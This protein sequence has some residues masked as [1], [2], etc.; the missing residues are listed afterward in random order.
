MGYY[1]NIS[2]KETGV[3]GF[4]VETEGHL[5]WLVLN[6]TVPTCSWYKGKGGI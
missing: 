4:V 5:F 1:S 3:V 6:F 2:L